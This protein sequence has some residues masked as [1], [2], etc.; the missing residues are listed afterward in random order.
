MDFDIHSLTSG[1]L[2]GIIMMVVGLV[3]I[4]TAVL[5]W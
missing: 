5:T 4:F 3:L 2:Y 1:Q